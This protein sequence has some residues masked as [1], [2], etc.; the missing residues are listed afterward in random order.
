MRR[1]VARPHAP[2]KR[3]VGMEV[4][5]FATGHIVLCIHDIEVAVNRV[6]DNAIRHLDAGNLRC[7]KELG[8]NRLV[9]SHVDNAVSYL[10]GE[11]L[12][13]ERH[14]HIIK[15]IANDAHIGDCCIDGSSSTPVGPLF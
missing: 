12:I 14:T 11:R 6:D 4:Q 5:Q 15:G 8:R 1:N 2:V 3:S 13:I 7:G 9:R 10:I